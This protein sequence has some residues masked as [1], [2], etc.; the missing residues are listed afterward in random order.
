MKKMKNMQLWVVGLFAALMLVLAPFNSTLAADFCQDLWGKPCKSIPTS[1]EPENPEYYFH[2][3]MHTSPHPFWYTMARGA[4]EAAKR[5]NVKVVVEMFPRESL[6]DTANRF[7]QVVGLKPDGMVTAITNVKLMDKPVRR[8]IKRGIPV[9][10]S[11]VPD[12]RPVGERLPYLLYV[13]PSE[14]LH[15]QLL[16]RELLK[17]RPSFKKV[18]ITNHQP[19]LSVLEQR[20]LGVKDVLEPLGTKVDTIRVSRNPSEVQEQVRAYFTRSPDT[21][22]FVSLATYVNDVARQFFREDGLT[23]KVVNITTEM[24]S[25]CAEAVRKGELIAMSDQQIFLQGYLPVHW[26]YL[27]KKWGFEPASDMLTGPV[28]ISKDNVDTVQEG[29]DG[30]WR[31]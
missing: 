20:I 12:L 10:A 14:F 31:F 22:G 4:I 26:L 6:E 29:I 8:A 5:Y 18:L 21:E 13:G 25:E 28:M 19:G 24:C 27:Y 23:G 11:N 2:I 30:K 16:A 15:G 3:V 7:D 9:V 17:H 1:Y